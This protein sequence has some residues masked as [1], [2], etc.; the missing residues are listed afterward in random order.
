MNDEELEKVYEWLEK[1]MN[2]QNLFYF[3]YSSGSIIARWKIDDK[4]FAIF[5]PK[6]IYKIIKIQEWGKENND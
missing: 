3:E 1:Y 6:V 2:K 5:Y 4:P